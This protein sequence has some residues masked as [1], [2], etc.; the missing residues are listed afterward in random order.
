MKNII[1][2]LI[3][4]FVVGCASSGFNR[5]TLKGQLGV[6][7]PVVTD[8]EI[9]KVL[10]LKPNLPKTFKLG[11]FFKNSDSYYQFSNWRWS[12]ED[13][14]I[15]LNLSKKSDYSEMITEVFQILPSTISGEG[16]LNSIR[17]AAARHGADAVLIVSGVGEVDRYTNNLGW[18]YFLIAPAL[19]VPGSEADALFMANATL[20]DVRNGYLYLTA[21]AESQTSNTYIAAY[22][23]E[24]KQLLE[25]SKNKALKKL[26]EELLK[27]VQGIK[28]R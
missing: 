16:D 2:I 9:E 27:M 15:F 22:G 5:G 23:K 19:F 17:L 8:A 12:D 3:C 11:V 6:K 18:S 13:K 20:W 10:A 7:T 25:V 24:N 1:C 26:D 4:G 21:E 28:K 14:N